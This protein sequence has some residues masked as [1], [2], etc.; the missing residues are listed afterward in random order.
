[1]SNVGSNFTTSYSLGLEQDKPIQKW[2]DYDGFGAYQYR[3]HKFPN[4]KTLNDLQK[5]RVFKVHAEERLR[6]NA[7]R[8][9]DILPKV[10]ERCWMKG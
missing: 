10:K 2:E 7:V 5:R 8:K 1:M 3:H 4:N 9:A 6:I